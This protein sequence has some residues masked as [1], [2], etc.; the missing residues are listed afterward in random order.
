[1]QLWLRGPNRRLEPNQRYFNTVYG[2]VSRFLNIA[3]QMAIFSTH[4][5]L[6]FDTLRMTRFERRC[7]LP[8]HHAETNTRS[9]IRSV[10]EEPLDIGV[11]TALDIPF[12]SPVQVA[13]GRGEIETP[14][15]IPARVGAEFD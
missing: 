10:R 15:F 8:R 2:V 12:W 7:S 6:S 1:M 13:L 14:A 5:E 4:A 11:H 9:D 3:A